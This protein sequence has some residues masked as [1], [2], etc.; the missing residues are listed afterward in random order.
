MFTGG[1]TVAVPEG[2]PGFLD[3]TAKNTGA[4]PLRVVTAPGI[5]DLNVVNPSGDPG[6]APLLTKTIGLESG[7][8]IQP[9]GSKLLRITFSTPADAPEDGKDEN[10]DFGQW[11]LV[12]RPKTT[13]LKVKD[14][15]T[16]DTFAVT[17]TNFPISSII[18]LDPGV[19]PPKVPE[20][21]TI[22]L[23]GIGA[24]SLIGYGWRW[25]KVAHPGKRTY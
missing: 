3:Y 14:T 4:N 24:V 6:D 12:V 15:K 17:S 1:G 13:L 10:S 19:P 11:D 9:G 7:V 5:G 25:R 8:I 21:T 2:D 18:V 22:T 23:L 16:E 20:P